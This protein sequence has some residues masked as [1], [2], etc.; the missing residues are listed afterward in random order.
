MRN[1][2]GPGLSLLLILLMGTQ[3][4]IVAQ[5]RDL[6]V[7]PGQ[8]IARVR[9][10]EKLDRVV[11]R[12]GPFDYGD[13]AAGHHW[14]TWQAHHPDSS[15]GARFDLDVYA[16]VNEIDGPYVRL[17]RVAS[18]QFHTAHGIACGSTLAQ[19]QNRYP[20][21]HRVAR[22][23]S[24]QTSQPMVIMDAVAQGIAFEFA[25]DR[26]GK[27]RAHSA[28]VALIVHPAGSLSVQDQYYPLTQYEA[29]K[30]YPATEPTSQARTRT[31][32]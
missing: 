5:S 22:Y 13:S 3:A 26:Q 8:R 21:A 24:P 12:L 11:E 20:Q 17:I 7:V 30:P 6:S 16:E 2:S 18:P 10:H 31:R 29:G 15:T 14:R 32:R 9:L 1:R 25:C 4:K 28:C 27:G 19:I 23:R